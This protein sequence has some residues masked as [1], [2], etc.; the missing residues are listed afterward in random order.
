MHTNTSIFEKLTTKASLL[1]AWRVIQQKGK[2]GG[3]DGVSV[4]FYSKNFD[5]NIN[6]LLE[7]LK[8]HSYVPEPYERISTP[9]EG[10]PG[11]YRHLSLPTINDKIVQQAFRDLVEPVFNRIFKDV[12]YAYRPQK[13]PAKAILRISH[14]MNHNRIKWV[15]CADIDL[16][17]DTMNH[18]F[19]LSEIKKM[20][21]EPEITKLINMWIKTG[22]VT[23]K[24]TYEDTAFGVA[25]GGIVSPLFSNIYLHPLDSYLVEKKCLYVRYADNFILMSQTRLQI[26]TFFNDTVY[27]LENVLKLRLNKQPDYIL[28]AERGFSFMGIFFR[29]NERLIDHS[30]IQRMENRIRYLVRSKLLYDEKYF[31]KQMEQKTEG[32]DNYYAKLVSPE[33]YAEQFNRFLKQS[34]IESISYNFK[35]RKKRLSKTDIKALLA[36]VRLFGNRDTSVK[37]KW[38]IEIADQ[39]AE[40]FRKIEQDQKNQAVIHKKQILSAKPVKKTSDTPS[41]ALPWEQQPAGKDE[42]QQ[43]QSNKDDSGTDPDKAASS[44]IEK[45]KARYKKIESVSR[46][47]VI[48]TIGVFIGKNR[49]NLVVKKKGKKIFDF[50]LEKLETLNIVSRGVTISSD[51]IMYCS[52]MAIPVFFG[53]GFGAPSCVLHNMVEGD[54]TLGL[55]QLQAVQDGEKALSIAA[56]FVEG[57]IRN[58]INLLKYYQRN[59]P[60]DSL[61]CT[62]LSDEICHMKSG[63]RKLHTVRLE[64]KEYGTARNRLMGYE[65]EAAKRYWKL[66]RILLADD[67]PDFPGRAQQGARDLVNSLLNYGYGFLYRQVWR[68]V[69]NSGLN[70]RISFLHSPQAEK[71]TL[72]FDIMEEFRP[73]AV[74]RVVFSMLTRREALK[75]EKKSGMLDNPSRKKMIEALLERQ[76]TAVK[77]RGAKILLKNIIKNQVRELCLH[78]QGEKNYRHFIGY[79]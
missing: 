4:K 58:Q 54:P 57:K 9:K 47:L 2:A 53:D 33:S 35:K 29:D 28:N 71:P 25:Q 19:L 64:V 31:F 3:V 70:S 15:A 65:A 60:A 61:Y 50:P 77:Y 59:R 79:Y 62:A 39:C 76:G 14:I 46:E 32:F 38:I 75:V 8:N 45:Q 17:F 44:A 18:Q 51:I 67:V 49:N 23:Q 27:F 5:S 68:E 34:I 41:G 43:E 1:D 12:S 74:D 78:L 42:K 66:V 24:G 16:F 63:I 48:E 55:M 21:D 56:E 22:V 6:S 72:V 7:S 26:E 10:K 69:I 73:Q 30:R 40:N 52:K 20:V 37:D 11:E 36:P 13:G